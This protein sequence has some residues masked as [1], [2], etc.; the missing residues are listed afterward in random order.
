MV[1]LMVIGAAVIPMLNVQYTPTSKQKRLHINYYWANASAR[2]VEQEVTSKLE[3][4]LA[5]ISGIQNMD[6]ESRKDGGRITLSFK[7]DANIDAV[8]FEISSKI[9]QI[10]NQLPEGVRYPNLSTSTSGEYTPPMLTYTVNANLPTWQIQQYTQKSIADVISKIDGV[11]QVDVNGATPFEWI[12][13]FDPER[14]AVSGITG[15]DIS[16][17]MNIQSSNMPLGLGQISRDE[18]IRVTLKGDDLSPEEWHKIVLKN[19]EGR[20]IHLGDVGTIEYKQSLP[21]SYYRLNGLNNINMSITPEKYVN[22]LLLTEKIKIRVDELREHLPDG[23]SIS[24]VSDSSVYIQKELSKIY[25]RSGLSLF[26]LLLFIYLV[27]R[28]L[29]YLLLIVV[30]LLANILIAFILYNIFDLEIHLYSLA[31]ITVSLGL[32]IDTSIIMTDHYGRY[33]NLKAFIAILAAL[34]TTI[35]ALSVVLFLPEEQRANLVDFSAVIIINLT[36]SMFISLFFIPALLEKF[37][38]RTLARKRKSTKGLRRTARIS[39]MY[40]R[41]ITWSKRHKWVYILLFVLTFGIPVQLLPPKLG[42]PEYGK[43]QDTLNRWQQMYNNT[44]GGDLYQQDLKPWIEPALGG[45]MRLFA[46]NA[47]GGGSFWNDP[48]RTTLYINAQL[49]EGCTVHQLNDIIIEMEN[50]LSQF[51]E[52]E[53]YQTFVYSYDNARIIVTFKPEADKSGF[54]Y[55]LKD[56][57]QSTVISLG[58]ATWAIYGVGQGFSNNIGGGG[59]KQHQI[60][61]KGYNYEQLYRYATNIIDTISK[62]QR[63]SGPEIMGS[64]Y[65]GLP[66][67]EFFLDFNF[68]KFGLYNINPREYYKAIEQQLFIQRLQS[69]YNN[70]Q[71]DNVTLVSS[72]SDRFDAW[73]MG[74]DILAVGKQNVKLSELGSIGKR[75]SGNNI[76]KS[77]QQYTLTVGFDFVGSYELANRF[78]KRQINRVSAELPIGFKVDESQ[79]NWWGSNNKTP[80]IL[81]M[82]VIAIIYFICSILFESLLQPLVIILMIPISFIGVFI[83]FWFFELNFDQGG[84]ASFVLLSGLVVNAGIYIINEYN[85][86]IRG[87][88]VAQYIRAFNRKIVPIMLTI[89]STVLGLIPFVVISR[90]PFWFSFASGAMGGMLFSVVAILIF[91]P[92]F[93]RAR[94]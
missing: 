62:N 66:S 85:G 52:I 12:I 88:G 58:G 80:Y 18:Q 36:V 50:F 79:M 55:M 17:A 70:G 45:T 19:S 16:M 13:S 72:G 78:V 42:V 59:Y 87:N 73:H 63:V 41:W 8:R 57:A 69:V 65:G 38:M 94:K 74:N 32:V 22:T 2:V 21:T 93:L 64:T 35:G 83:T 3:G 77:N 6:S 71:M 34:L 86:S 39:H 1:V 60:T 10:Y 67:I 26:I 30:T 31:G 33:R 68:E 14:C 56:A 4:V 25:F 24:L 15:D 11:K 61:L 92:I 90:E 49:P 23:Y 76:Y 29:R 7:E 40:I 46:K 47:F 75:R 91:M 53:A 54:P 27:S 9:K 84:F 48:Q 5:P 89:L 37:P 20:L 81:I 28:N 82:L 51:D 44:V 43:S